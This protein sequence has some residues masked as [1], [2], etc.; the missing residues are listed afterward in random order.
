[1]RKKM[2]LAA[3]LLVAVSLSPFASDAASVYVK[4]KPSGATSQSP[5]IK[6]VPSNPQSKPPAE[7]PHMGSMPGLPDSTPPC[8]EEDAKL[9]AKLDKR[10]MT[11]S[12]EFEP[13]ESTQDAKEWQSN[14]KNK[15]SIRN[16]IDLYSRCAFVVM[17]QRQAAGIK[18]GTPSRQP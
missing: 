4:K 9:V 13:D 7:A 5:I 14:F 11:P 18:P 3:L 10:I 1:V 6:P 8:T 16:L 2:V 15:D 17:Q 12:D